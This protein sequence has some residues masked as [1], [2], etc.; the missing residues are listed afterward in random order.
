M[1]NLQRSVLSFKP[2]PNASV[3]AAYATSSN[4]VGAEFDGTSAPIRLAL[5]SE[6]RSNQIFGPEKNKA[7]EIGTKWEL[8]DRHLLVTGALFQTEKDNA[9]ETSNIQRPAHCCSYPARAR[10]CITA[11]AAYRPRHRSRRRRQD[12]RQVEHLRRPGADAVGGDEVA[13]PSPTA[14]IRPMSGCRSPTSRTSRS[15]CSPSTSSPNLGVGGQATYRSKIYGG[16]LLAANQGTR[17]AEL[18]ALR[19]LRRE[20]RSTRTGT[21]SC[22]CN[23]IFNK[24]YYDAFYQSAAPFVLVAP[25]RAACLRWSLSAK[26]Y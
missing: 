10:S 24:L 16:T 9:R 6:R 22:S 12:H 8:F 14:V 1:P 25:G 2:L 7:A 23:N 4:P 15:T 21:R 19:R 11:G 13:R 26:F 3:Y 17:A 5:R 20:A 18:L